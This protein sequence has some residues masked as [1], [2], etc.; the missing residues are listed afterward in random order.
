[1][2]PAKPDSPRRESPAGYGGEDV[3]LI[4]S[5]RV[6]EFVTAIDEVYER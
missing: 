5:Q 6:E 1:V 2:K 4:G 3:T